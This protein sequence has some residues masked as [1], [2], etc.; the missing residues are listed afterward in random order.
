VLAFVEQDAEVVIGLVAATV[1]VPTGPA[2]VAVG[3]RERDAAGVKVG[4]ADGAPVGDGLVAAGGRVG[5]A[6]VGENKAQPEET[7]VRTTRRRKAIRAGFLTIE[8][9]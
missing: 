9:L 8:Q 5:G 4:A 3:E 2:G 1:A 7:Q 6:A